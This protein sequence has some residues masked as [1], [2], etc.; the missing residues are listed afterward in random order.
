MTTL[1]LDGRVLIVGGAGFAE[2]QF[3]SFASAVLYRP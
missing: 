3:V 1:L 2:G